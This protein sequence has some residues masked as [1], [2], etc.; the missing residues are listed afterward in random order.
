MKTTTHEKPKP[1]WNADLPETF[2]KDAKISWYRPKVDPQLLAQLMECSDWQGYRQA[3][4]H[5]GLWAVTGTLAY[6]AFHHVTATNWYWTVPALLAA[7]CAHGTVGS[8]LG[9][10]ACH[11]LSHKT[12]F[13][14]KA[15][16]EFFHKLFAFLAWHDRVWFRPSHVRHH[17]VTV[18]RNHDGEVVLPQRFY[19]HDWQF[20]LGQFAWNPVG[21]WGRIKSMWQAATGKFDQSWFRFVIPS[22]N[23]ELRRQHRNWARFLLLGHLALAAVFIASGH[24]FLIVLVNFGTQYCGWLGTLC[25]APQHYGLSPN[26]PDHRLSCRTY[27]CSRF[28]GF[29]YW[30]MQYHVEHHM[31]PA[32]PFFNLPKLRQAIV[33]DLPP[34]PHGLRA[35]WNEVLA[36]HREQRTNPHYAFVPKLP[37]SGGTH[38]DDQL[39]RREAALAA[40]G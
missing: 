39:L 38:A 12:P 20:W 26:V 17:Q 13:K 23:T 2:S 14:T 33:H 35:T 40:S 7:L 19:F 34:A 36:I 31:F 32:V 37:G 24:W 10:T 29:L 25:G 27:T 21:T 8:F 16:N 6:W 22:E 9:G 1:F 11:E 5:L 18:Y 3:L 28:I 30:N 4:G 15:V